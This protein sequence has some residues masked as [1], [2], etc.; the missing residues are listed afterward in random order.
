MAILSQLLGAIGTGL[1]GLAKGAGTL[2]GS[3]ITGVSQFGQ[4]A[5][6]ILPGLQGAVGLAQGP[7]GAIEDLVGGL[8][9]DFGMKGLGGAIAQND[10]PSQALFEDIMGQLAA[11]PE[12][13]SKRL[14]ELAKGA[15]AVGKA[16]ESGMMAQSLLGENP[17][18]GALMEGLDR[19]V[20]SQEQE[21]QPSLIQS[22]GQ[23]PGP[24]FQ[25]EH[26]LS[27][28]GMLGR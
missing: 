24:R 9:S 3:G 20:G 19:R 11:D 7:A 13:G 5:Q 1:G 2:A 17:D 25:F 28:M 18:L 4:G 12:A 22:Q 27:V 23:A 8:F 16:R 6:A 21:Q 10:D 15:K 14:Q 26:P